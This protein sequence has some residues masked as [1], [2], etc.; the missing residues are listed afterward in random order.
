MLDLSAVQGPLVAIVG[1]NGAGKST[2]LELLMGALDRE[3]PT[4]G[5]LADLATTRDA[6]VEARVVNGAS[7][8]IRQTVDAQ[9]GKSEA[10]VLDAAGVP[11]LTDGKV[12]T[13][14]AWRLAHLP[15]REVLLASTFAAQGS[16]GFIE[17]SATE[18]KR[19]LLRTLGIESIEG[20][21]DRAREHLRDA[22]AA[23]ETARARIEDERR[24]AGDVDALGAELGIE[25]SGVEAATKSVD[26][27]RAAER[28]AQASAADADEALREHERRQAEAK[29]LRDRAAELDAK[30]ADLDK[31][32]ANNRAV[33]E[34]AGAIRAAV[35]AAHEAQRIV[36]EATLDA[37][38]ERGHADQ[39][40][41]ELKR[42]EAR[43]VETNTA[44]AAIERRI[45]RA[46]AV[47]RDRAAIEAAAASLP[48]KEQAV[49][50]AKA[51]WDTAGAE[52]SRLHERRFYGAEERIRN[53]RG[54]LDAIA[55]AEPSP[56]GVV[57]AAVEIASQT[58]GADDEVVEGAA[59]A[60]VELRAA[61]REMDA[62]MRLHHAACRALQDAE[63][64]AARAAEIARAVQDK[65]AAEREL[66]EAREKLVELESR[67]I[68][69]ANEARAHRE[70]FADAEQRRVDA[71]R[72]KAHHE[73]VAKKA[74]RL[75]T[76]EGRI[77]EIVP[78]IEEATVETAKLRVRADEIAPAG[79]APTTPD[80]DAARSRVEG[81]EREL[82]S[83]EA[84]VAVLEKDLSNARDVADRIAKLEEQRRADEERLADWTLLADS[85][86]KDGLQAL[87]IDAAGPELTE[88]CNSL[89]HEAFGTRFTIS[90]DTT[91]RSA[92]GKRDLEVMEINV[93]D[94]ER[95]RDGSASALS[96]GEKVIVGEAISLAL[97]TITCRQNGVE[98]PTICR[99]ESGAALDPEN[100]MRYVAMLRRACALIGADKILLVSHSEAVRE[101]CD[102]R[103]KIADGRLQVE[104]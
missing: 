68:E 55:N 60:P 45:E 41:R 58:L 67:G 50:E 82:R 95:G 36:T 47:L 52:A 43:I 29:A 70:A 38:R 88:I 54:G 12:R 101:M 73:P 61:E 28:Q 84:R 34:E 22:K 42:V 66:Q 2:L 39:A 24:R 85:L 31:R 16:G 71:E 92:D 89:L 48:E 21:A 59:R 97:A 93:V 26:E 27:A 18:R 20:L 78:Q 87:L 19:L 98:K 13:F 76:A 33:L 94:T 62:A 7:W 3:T 17:M 11:A 104:G 69:L 65:D 5:S 56:P 14:D 53:L 25:R 80:L 96:G 77:A 83:R 30:I 4:R 46:I 6:Y 63:R 8:V 81:A 23:L 99:D 72:E 100:A 51:S 64:L 1:P 57:L 86:G 40:E 9:S 10:L 75:A 37:G 102:S 90:L 91:K 74:E 79:A 49:S 35:E 44:I 103:I 32:L 15:P